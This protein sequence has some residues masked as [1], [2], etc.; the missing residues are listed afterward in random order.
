MSQA[1]KSIEINCSAAHFYSVLTGFEKQKDFVSDLQDVKLL[2]KEGETY[3]VR[4]K[5]R[6]IKE[7]E[8]DLKHI[9][10]PNKRMTWKLLKGQFMK[11]NEGSWD[12]EELGPDKIRATYS[13]TLKL[14]A[15]VP[16]SVTTQLAQ[17][18]LP[19]MLQEF[20]TYAESTYKGA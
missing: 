15:L 14:S 18:G 2:S 8:Y 17:L 1:Q 12:I 19:K 7:I 11:V 4:Y 3:T 20:K 10:E 9:G 13:I 5:V 16:S 6:L